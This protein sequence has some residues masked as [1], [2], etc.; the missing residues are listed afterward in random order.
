MILGAGT[1]PRLKVSQT[2]VQPHKLAEE[3]KILIRLTHPD[4]PEDGITDY[5]YT[6]N[7]AWDAVTQPRLLSYGF[8]TNVVPIL[9]LDETDERNPIL[10]TYVGPVVVEENEFEGKTQRR[11]ARVGEYVVERLD[12]DAKRSLDAML[13]ARLGTKTQTFGGAPK[14]AAPRTAPRPAAPAMPPPNGPDSGIDENIGF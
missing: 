5:L 10:N 14:K 4:V 2:S 1:Y 7:K 13:S 8:D 11:V 9:N 3:P 12:P 6:S